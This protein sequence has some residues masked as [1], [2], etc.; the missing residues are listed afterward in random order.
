MSNDSQFPS[1]ST[2]ISFS[3]SLQRHR[4]E[5]NW[6]KSARKSLVR[7]L[8]TFLLPTI[9][10]NTNDA[11]NNSV[12]E[13]AGGTRKDIRGRGS[14]PIIEHER[15]HGDVSSSRPNEGGRWPAWESFGV[16]TKLLGN[17]H[18][19]LVAYYQEEYWRMSLQ[20]TLR[21]SNV[22]ITYKS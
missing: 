8:V 4:N 2:R 15:S 3:F 20:I 1:K 12:W 6:L 17:E 22:I 13:G 7:M 16:T 19:R 18:W 14:G 5:S 10:V 21:M 9:L 11:N